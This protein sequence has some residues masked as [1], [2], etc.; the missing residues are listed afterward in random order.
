[1]KVSKILILDDDERVCEEL[2][3]Y[4][5]RKKYIVFSTTTPSFAFKI[6]NRTRIDLLFL[7]FILPE[8]NGIKVL[9]IVKKQYPEIK[10]IM[11][12]GNGNNEIEKEAKKNGAADYLTKPFLHYEVQKAIECLKN[13]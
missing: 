6:L 13:E 5:I 3:E 9:K 8:M 12:S 4:L 7:D 2:S 1:M 10:V 11:I